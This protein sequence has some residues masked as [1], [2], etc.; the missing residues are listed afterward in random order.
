MRRFWVPVVGVITGV[1]VVLLAVACPRR[2]RATD[3][4]VAAA[5]EQALTADGR[6]GASSGTLAGREPAVAGFYRARNFSPAWTSGGQPLDSADQLLDA[7]READAEGLRPSD[8]R[9]A[10]IEAVLGTLRAPQQVDA[11]LR[12]RQ[13]AHAEIVL[14]DAF[15]LYA[16]HLADGKVD[17][18]SGRAR[19][20]RASRRVN[21]QGL[22]NQA[23]R[24]GTVAETLAA[25][26]PAHAHYRNLRA[27]RLAARARLRRLPEA[28]RDEIARRMEHLAINMERWRWM[29]RDLGPRY[30]LVDVAAFELVEM[31][32]G[33]E[34]ARMKIVGGT[35]TWQTPDFTSAITDFSINPSWNAPNHVLLAELLAYIKQDVNYLANNKMVLLRREGDKEVPLDPKSIDFATLTPENVD[36]RLRQGAGPLN[37][38]GRYKFNVPNPHDV[39]L[40]DTPYQD[41]FKKM[42]RMFS[43]GCVRV[44]RPVD[45]ALFLLN[46]DPAWTRERLVAAAEE[47]TE[48]RVR[49]S[50][51][52]PAHVLYLT[53]VADAA[54]NVRSRDDVYHRDAK[55][56]AA[57]AAA[58]SRTTGRAG[59]R[60]GNRES[61]VESRTAKPVSRKPS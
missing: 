49:L 38:L 25:V 1:V 40:H 24:A 46:G 42:P 4:A 59:Q 30:V 45:F 54:G 12:S 8:Y 44:E 19:W 16:S 3:T 18:E 36:F 23:L 10:E 28:R 55:M 7:V 61:N 47:L 41:D 15:L 14:S 20:D 21:L 51:P 50:R 31:E 5:L 39:Y 26:A 33:R 34:R 11:G 32:G 43:H 2:S 13:A 17:L 53:A 57:L 60:V 22:L 37:V 58:E 9:A 6:G 48:Q 56:A 27:A 52:V 29:P 35:D